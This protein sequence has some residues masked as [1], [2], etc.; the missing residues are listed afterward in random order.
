M[1]ERRCSPP[2][3]AA[4]SPLAQVNTPGGRLL[5][6]HAQLHHLDRLAVDNLLD[7]V[8]PALQ[9]DRNLVGVVVLLI[10]ANDAAERT[11][12]MIE[13]FLDHRHRN[14]ELLH[15]AGAG[16]AQIM[17][18]PTAR[19]DP[20]LGTD[21]VLHLVP[22]VHRPLTV[23]AEHEVAIGEPRARPDQRPSLPAQRGRVWPPVFAALAR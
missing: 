19:G 10:D 2:A 7:A 15:A 5:L 9:R 11:R 22:V 17:E 20:R 14:P 18:T 1:S 23:S 4:L 6:A 8:R 21:P 3:P 13:C 12:H 16:P